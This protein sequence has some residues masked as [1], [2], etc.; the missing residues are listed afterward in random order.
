MSMRTSQRLTV[1][2]TF[3]NPLDPQTWSGTPAN[4]CRI[5]KQHGCLDDVVDCQSYAGRGA[6]A[7]L[8]LLSRLRYGG[9]EDHRR[10]ELLTRAKANYV[11]R[12]LK[13]GN[14][15]VLHVGNDHLPLGGMVGDR[16]HFLYI[17]YTWHLELQNWLNDYRP[18]EEFIQHS[19]AMIRAG[20]QQMTHIF[21]IAQYL[22]DDLVNF[23]GIAPEKITAVGTGRGMI[24]PFYG[25]KD[26]AGATILFVAKHSF[27]CKGGNI[28][29]D[30]FRI[31]HQR[32]PRLRL[33]L[34][35]QKD[36]KQ[37]FGDI[38]GVI[39]YDE[40]V[41]NEL[42][43]ELFN[44]ATLLAMP[45]LREPWGLVYLEALSCRT[46]VIG[47]NRNALPEMTQNG[48]FGFLL[49]EA[50]PPAFAE[51]VLHAC[52]D[53]ARLKQ[54][55]IEGQQH[56]LRYYTWENTVNRMLSV[57]TRSAGKAVSYR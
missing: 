5:L 42:L 56:C 16:A 14:S 25:E 20:L 39:T 4:I 32:D 49:D 27:E 29:V 1:C 53:R 44:T 28:V 35:G 47:L 36:Y 40:F 13:N 50:T 19:Q 26:P 3:G 33:I 7:V 52:Q 11:A 15:D 57:M 48:R 17:D 41:S 10:G 2:S 22:K 37:R 18:T 43:Q 31:A 21:P 30:G 51:M 54:M 9:H 12:R 23:Y 55:G 24:K 34:V 38:P 8:N 45:A 46:P 6:K